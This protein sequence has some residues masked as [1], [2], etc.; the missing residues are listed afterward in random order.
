MN[1]LQNIILVSSFLLFSSCKKESKPVIP[2]LS[3]TG[4]EVT[5]GNSGVTKATLTITLSAA[6][7]N[8]V[9]LNYYTED[10]TA[11]AG[12][13]YKAVTDGVITF[14]AGETSK[15]IDLEIIPNTYLE[16]N[17]SFILSIDNL[18][19]ATVA[20]SHATVKIL[21]DDSYM[22]ESD[23]NG[24]LTPNTYPG[25]TLAWS[26]EFNDAQLNTNY[27]TYEKG[28]SGWGN[29]ELQNY[30]D[31]PDNVFTQNG[32]LTIKAIKTGTNT[33]TSGR[34][35][36][37]GKKEF[38]YGRIDIRAKLPFGQGIWPALWMLGG[39]ISTVNWPA[40][41]EIDIME[42]LGH[43]TN[44]VYGTPH[45]YEEGHKYQTGSF[46]L[47]SGNFT[48]KFHV[49]TIIWQENI[50]TWYVDYQKYHQ[51][52]RVGDPFDKPAF[53]IMNVAVGGNWPGIPDATT[54]F[55]QSMVVD[56][57]RVFQ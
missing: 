9:S 30:T 35:I 4:V 45:Y 47:P 56:Y 57:V 8:E 43:E 13:D 46:S 27:W 31:S 16:L 28:A 12:I 40:C 42:Y 52:T 50:I 1:L 48:E 11:K 51:F 53:F 18:K 36:T 3:I 32:F 54:T 2:E 10:Y 44:K 20:Y 25:M 41:G 14:A 24:I 15:K 6:T 38:T 39:N 55:P 37:K 17:K 33:Y 21:N 5:E 34:L 7:T 26:D 49:F 22:P 29:N 19:N 23:I